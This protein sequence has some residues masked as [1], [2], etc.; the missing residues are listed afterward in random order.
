M[1]VHQ[2]GTS[3]TTVRIVQKPENTL[4]IS[5]VTMLEEFNIY[6]AMHLVSS[7]FRGPLLGWMGR[8]FTAE[9]DVL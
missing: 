8:V 9:A 3:K 5:F 6:R 4:G 2:W 1:V 7:I